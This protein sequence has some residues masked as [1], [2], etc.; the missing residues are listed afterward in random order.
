MP[1]TTA[2][3]RC[4]ITFKTH[5]NRTGH[6]SGCHRTFTGLSAFDR[7]QTI[8]GGKVTCHDPATIT[9]GDPPA[10]AYTSRVDGEVTY[11]AL[12]VDPGFAGRMDAARGSGPSNA[13]PRGGEDGF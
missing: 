5:G 2:G 11:W 10:A 4:G 13:K 1:A 12:A 7:H 3:C 9:A 6:C 8:T